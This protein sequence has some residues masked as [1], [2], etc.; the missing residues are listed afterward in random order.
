MR[1]T[2]R[3]IHA[4][5]D[6]VDDAIEQEQ[7]NARV[8]MSGEIGVD[9]GPHVQRPEPDGGG[10]GEEALRLGDGFVFPL[11]GFGER[12]KNAPADGE[13]ALAGLRELEHAGRANEQGTAESRLER[14]DGPGNGG[15]RASERARCARE[16]ALVDS[17]DEGFHAIE[18]IHHLCISRK[19]ELRESTII[20][21]DEKV[22]V[23]ERRTR[24]LGRKRFHMTRIPAL[25]PA[26][27]TGTVKTLLAG[28]DKGLGMTPNLFRVAAQS[29]SVLEALT[30]MFGATSK[31]HL[32]AKTREAIAL[33]VSEL[34]RCDYCLSAHS[35]LGKGAGLGDEDIEKARDATADDKKLAATLVFAK[36]ITEKR[37]RVSDYDV[38]LARNAGLGNA[39]IL[40][41]VANVALTTFTNYLNEVAKTEIDFPVVTHR[42]R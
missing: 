12:A 26:S 9:E 33:T 18:A 3:G 25:D 21:G 2:N 38:E 34:D 39:D 31:G 28:V 15:D 37:G 11:F 13:I 17:G 40:D 6:D 32:N 41:V 42:P 24:P 4:F 30:A 10:D 7:S 27:A 8:R 22:H 23:H 14:G 20:A 35:A 36:T 16:A 19:Q 5:V 1:E 29:P